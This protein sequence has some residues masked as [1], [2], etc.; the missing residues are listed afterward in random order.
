MIRALALTLALL[1]AACGTPE[2]LRGPPGAASMPEPSGSEAP[3]PRIVTPTGEP[4]ITLP[5]ATEDG[6]TPI[7]APR[8]DRAARP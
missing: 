7:A 3:L 5:V 4:R 1:P 8:S 6:F 2:V